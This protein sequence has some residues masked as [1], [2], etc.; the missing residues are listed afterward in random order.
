MPIECVLVIANTFSAEKVY[1]RKRIT[2]LDAVRMS[3]VCRMLAWA[4][5]C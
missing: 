4:T 5:G 1:L 2:T 3:E